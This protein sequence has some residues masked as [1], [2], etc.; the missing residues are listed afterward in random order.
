MKNSTN[1]RE[2]IK[3]TGLVGAGVWT[4]TAL[5][6]VESNSPNQKIQFACFGV[7]GKGSSDTADAARRGEVIAICD[8]DTKRLKASQR[9]Y[10]NAKS[11]TDYRELLSELGD[12]IDAVTVSTPDHT[13][14]I[15]AQQAMKMGKHC[16]AQ[17]PLTRTIQ[18][19][20]L[21]A[22]I[23]K[24]KGLATQMGNQGTA[25]NGLRR[26]AAMIQAGI[27]GDV[28]EVHVWTNRPVWPQ[29][30]DRSEEREV[31][32]HLKW[33]LWLG[34]A[35]YRPFG[36]NYH[37]KKWRGW[38]DFGCGALGDMGCHTMNLPFHA[39]DLRDPTNIVAKTSGHNKDSYPKFSKIDY[40]F[41]ETD[42]RKA[43]KMIWYD[44]GQLPDAA[45]FDGKK[46]PKAGSLFIGSEGK[47]FSPGDYGE[48][49]ELLGGPEKIEVDYVRSNGHFQE[50]VD[51]INGKGKSMSDFTTT[52]VPLTETVLLGNLAVWLD[53]TKSVEWDAKNMTATNAPELDQLIKPKPRAGWE[54]S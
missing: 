14:A 49:F 23:A 40:S 6:A 3:Y 13:H 1:R 34:P 47:L 17:K 38:W 11:F 32:E 48:K 35:N 25:H 4:S 7:G 12:K 39:L 54:M 19:A 42:K 26:A 28:S 5:G 50:W 9:R 2:F 20:R 31:P 45:L 29:G 18:D 30:I 52:A 46:V 51:A 10:P 37:P 43:V 8:V 53:G 27:I 15:I 22:K 21:L 16:F 44:G 41:A 33:D 36:A 24:E